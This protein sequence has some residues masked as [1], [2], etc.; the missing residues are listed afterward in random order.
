MPVTFD[1]SEP[2]LAYYQQQVEE[3]RAEMVR[4]HEECEQEMF[5]EYVKK[6]LAIDWNEDFKFEDAATVAKEFYDENLKATDP[7]PKEVSQRRVVVAGN[8]AYPSYRDKRFWQ[9]EK[10]ISVDVYDGEILISKNSVDRA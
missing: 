6:R 2:R 5:V 4:I 7:M 3:R 10:E 9:W 8:E 1:L